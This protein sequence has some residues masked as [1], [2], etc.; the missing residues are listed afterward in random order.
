MIIIAGIAGSG[1]TTQ[2]ELLSRRLNCPFFSMGELLRRF[3]DKKIQTKMQ[4]GEIVSNKEIQPIVEAAFST[5]DA[6]D[7]EVITDGFPRSMAQAN[8]L[9]GKIEAGDIKFR[10]FIHII[11]PES[12]ALDR[13]IS[14]GRKDDT[15]EAIHKRFEEY[16]QQMDLITALFKDHNLKV[17]DVDGVGTVEEVSERIWKA[18][19]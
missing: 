18:V 9:V 10:A 7:S 1:K 13:L 16:A 4:A 5:H 14:R 3:G 17:V 15:K 12:L 11:V 19:A 2:A 8:W 6:K